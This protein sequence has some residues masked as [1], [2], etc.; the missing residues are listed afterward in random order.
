M[1]MIQVRR[2]VGGVLVAL[3][4]VSAG[5][6]GDTAKDNVA[7]SYTGGSL[8]VEDLE[9]HRQIMSRQRMFR[10]NPERLT[11]EFVTEHAVN[12]EMIIA[13]G[14]KEKLQQDPRLRAEIHGFM[15][16]L[17][18]KVM[19]EK[20]VPDIDGKA[21]TDAEVRDYY[22]KNKASYRTP[23]QYGVSIIK[24]KDADALARLRARIAAG[25]LSFADAAARYSTDEKS[26]KS[27]GYIGLWALDRLP[28]GLRDDLE[29]MSLKQIS[30]VKKSKDNF[31]LV[32]LLQKTEPH[33]YTF[34][35]KAAYVRNDLLYS[36]Y[37]EEWRK[38]YEQLRKEFKVQENEAAL[39]R[40]GK[41]KPASEGGA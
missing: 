37:R 1:R 14:L 35:E 19:Q 15:S 39:K 13:K 29:K 41:E 38:T 4:A 25:E 7:V 6:C 3:L 24:G 31:Y 8:T 26:R 22:E 40:F 10:D 21:F 9:A 27:K 20:L 32:Q 16:D 2:M 5:G 33:Q 23:V 28:P 18:L 30:D 12:M 36:R 34:K 11:P 17:F